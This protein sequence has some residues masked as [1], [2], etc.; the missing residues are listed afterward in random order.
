MRKR[1]GVTRSIRGTK[2]QWFVNQQ[3]PFW[4]ENVMK[5]FVD[6][7]YAAVQFSF[8]KKNISHYK[9]NYSPLIDVKK[10]VEINNNKLRVVNDF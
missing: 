2:V 9:Q 4:K 7:N 1:T 6:S 8:S 5:I 10:F 3:S